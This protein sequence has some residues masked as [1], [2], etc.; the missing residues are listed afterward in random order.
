MKKSGY[1]LS[2]AIA[3]FACLAMLGS[4]ASARSAGTLYGDALVIGTDYESPTAQISSAGVLTV[5]S[6]TNTGGVTGTTG[7]FTDDV[8]VAGNLAVTGSQADE[9]DT[10]YSAIAVSSSIS[11]VDVSFL[12]INASGTLTSTATPFISTTT[13]ISGQVITLM[14]G[15][16][17]LTLDDEGSTTGTLL[18]LGDT[19]RALGAGDIL[20]LRYY[21]GKWYEEGFVNN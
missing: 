21:S 11:P 16:N 19:S 3:A 9:P 5:T 18:E 14:G 12:V 6:L 2:L 4:D 8:S 1:L 17:V 13:A 15:S 10:S 7:V 20:R